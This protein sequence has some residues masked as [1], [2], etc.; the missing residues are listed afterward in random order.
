MR[1]AGTPSVGFIES[2][3]SDQC[4]L[5]GESL[6]IPDAR[7]Q[8]FSRIVPQWRRVLAYHQQGAP[9]E[10]LRI[11]NF[12]Q[13][14]WRLC[15]S[16]RACRCNPGIFYIY[17]RT[18]SVLKMDD[19][20]SSRK[21][22]PKCI[23][24]SNIVMLRLCFGVTTM[25]RFSSFGVDVA[26][27]VKSYSPWLPARYLRGLLSETIIIIIIMTLLMSQNP[28]AGHKCPTNRGD[29]NLNTIKS[30]T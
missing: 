26:L 20:T 19:L 8:A 1:R 25:F 2:P 21:N 22:P 9:Q 6:Q 24:V 30:K 12:S 13:V 4:I 28:I 17:T 23:D 16:K 10:L 27:F 5:R 29:F 15:G 18:R 11:Q 14:T 7:K 3:M